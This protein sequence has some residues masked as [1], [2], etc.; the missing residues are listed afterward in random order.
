MATT[1]NG[2]GM[3]KNNNMS[4]ETTAYVICSPS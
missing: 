3:T 4:I 1:T 2:N